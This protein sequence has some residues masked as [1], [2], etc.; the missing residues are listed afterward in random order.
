MRIAILGNSGSGKSTLAHAIASRFGL[1]AL[2]LDRFAWEPGRI[3]VARD[4]EAARAD[5]AAFCAAHEGWVIEG[6]Y[7]HL[8]QATLAA[9][10][11]LLFLEPGVDTCLAHC[12]QRPWEPHKYASKA[13][14]DEKL[15]F[16]LA[17]VREYYSRDGDLSLKAHQA[18]FDDYPGPKIKLAAPVGPAFIQSLAARPSEIP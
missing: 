15:A 6:C 14:Q 10:P 18:L 3:A 11:R 13:D 16:L 2:D 12:H 5:V 17:W 7:A 8:I 1:E 9:T 4:P